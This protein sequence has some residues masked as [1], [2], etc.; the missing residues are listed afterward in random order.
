MFTL[1]TPVNL[2]RKRVSSVSIVC[3]CLFS[4]YCSIQSSNKQKE[5]EEKKT[6][7]IPLIYSRRF[8]FDHVFISNTSEY[9]FVSHKKKKKKTFMINA[10]RIKK[11]VVTK[12]I[13]EIAYQVKPTHGNKYFFK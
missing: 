9:A 8:Y 10:H 6:H 3:S 5:E 4:R 7:Q 11:N 2:H 1:F 12:H 13:S